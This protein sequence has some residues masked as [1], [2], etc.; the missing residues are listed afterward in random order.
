GTTMDGPIGLRDALLKHSDMVLRNFTENLMTYALGR[1]LEYPDMP[2]VRS[3]VDAAAAKNNRL[4]AFII[5]IVTHPSFR[6]SEA[7]PGDAAAKTTAA[8]QQ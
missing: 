5:G 2:A 7:G 3:I 4:S 8:P 1:R 6:M